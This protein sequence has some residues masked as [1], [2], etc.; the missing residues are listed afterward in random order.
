MRLKRPLFVP[1]RRIEQIGKL[2]EQ[3]FFSRRAKRR[4]WFAGS[5]RAGLARRGLLPRL[6]ENAGALFSA[7][8]SVILV[9]ALVALVVAF[10]RE[11][12]QDSV[13]LETFVAPKDLVEQGY[14]VDGHRR[15]DARRNPRHQHADRG[16]CGRA[17]RSSSATRCP[18]SRSRTAAFR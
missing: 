17:A 7:T 12:R 11:L 6:A 10:I 8:L 13:L 2:A 9:V 4:A 5:A 14:H 15:E 1:G 18:T 16:R 3:P